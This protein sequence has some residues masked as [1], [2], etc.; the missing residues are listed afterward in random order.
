MQNENIVDHGG[1]YMEGEGP[2]WKNILQ[3]HMCEYVTVSLSTGSIH[4]NKD[5]PPI[6][7]PTMTDTV[8]GFPVVFQ[9]YSDRDLFFNML[10][11]YQY[12]PI[13]LAVLVNHGQKL[14]AQD[15]SVVRMANYI[16]TVSTGKLE[17]NE[18]QKQ[19]DYT[20]LQ[21]VCANFLFSQSHAR[22]EHYQ[23]FSV[24]DDTEALDEDTEDEPLVVFSHA[25]TK[26]LHNKVVWAD[27][28]FGG[29]QTGLHST[30]TVVNNWARLDLKQPLFNTD[31]HNPKM[32]AMIQRY[33]DN[34]LRSIQDDNRPM[35]SVKHIVPTCYTHEI[36]LTQTGLF[37]GKNVENLMGRML[38]IQHTMM[39]SDPSNILATVVIASIS[40][41]FKTH[42]YVAVLSV[43]AKKGDEVQHY[44]QKDILANFCCL[45]FRALHDKEGGNPL[46]VE[47]THKDERVVD[48]DTV[49]VSNSLSF[50]W[51]RLFTP[52][53]P[54]SKGK[55]DIQVG[56]SLRSLRHLPR[57]AAKTIVQG[58]LGI[59]DCK[60]GDM[61]TMAGWLDGQFEALR[62]GNLSSAYKGKEH[63]RPSY[64]FVLG[65][66]NANTKE[67]YA[68]IIR[69][70]P[71]ENS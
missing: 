48:Y 4:T 9:N 29:E 61:A 16:V 28:A 5:E 38:C 12:Q 68:D 62:D 30:R 11:E 47:E 45:A 18:H 21:Y 40:E 56:M 37:F 43:A 52:Q 58:K 19:G 6:Y 1:A 22:Q 54:T 8:Y 64:A 35:P 24:D 67:S 3:K 7:R 23:Y 10:Q 63:M 34:D 15:N 69:P 31:A 20:V 32:V 25:D 66:G 27:S 70:W 49:K 39:P 44:D 55:E 51:G 59:P 46:Y 33:F 41:P 50:Y 42:T 26:R 71:T 65:E 36:C 53:A 57:N 13:V 17:S 14:D 60:G 2:A